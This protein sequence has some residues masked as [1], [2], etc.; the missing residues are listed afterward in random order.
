M[1]IRCVVTGRTPSGKSVIAKD[2]LVE[3]VTLD[4]VPGFEFHRVWGGDAVPQLPSD[5]TP[6]PHHRYFPPAGGYRFYFYVVPPDEQLRSAY[7]DVASSLGEMQ[8]KLPGMAE[9]LDPTQPGMHT[10]DSIDF[11]IVISGEL[12]LQVDDGAEVLLKAGDCVIQN[13]TRHAWH[14]RSSENCLVAV[15]IV[16]ATPEHRKFQA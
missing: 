2:S 13:G 3:P 5:G 10:T 4:A 14:N 1:K 15:A 9:T 12:Y 16:G 11:D 6:T 7:R 8:A